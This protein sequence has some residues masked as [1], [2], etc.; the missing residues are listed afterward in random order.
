MRDYYKQEVAAKQA[1]IAEE[2]A[3][4]NARKEYLQQHVANSTAQADNNASIPIYN[5]HSSIAQQESDSQVA[6]AASANNSYYAPTLASY[7]LRHAH[8][9][10]TMLHGLKLA[11]Q[12][13]QTVEGCVLLLRHSLPTTLYRIQDHFRTWQPDIISL[14]LQC[15]R[16]LLDCNATRD[17]VL[18]PS[19]GLTAEESAKE[20]G[21]SAA[22][23][24]A[25]QSIVTG[26]V[27]PVNHP[28]D[29]N[30]GQN[31][32]ESN[33]AM[34]TSVI[35]CDLLFRYG[36]SR[37]RGV[38]DHSLRCLM[39]CSRVEAHRAF[40]FHCNLPHYVLQFFQEIGL[41][42]VG[43]ESV[44]A[45]LRLL[46][47][48][49]TT[50]HRLQRVL[51]EYKAIPFLC[52]AMK[53]FANSADVLIPAIALLHRLVGTLPQA[54][55]QALDHQVLSFVIPALSRLAH[56]AVIQRTALL[57]VQLLTKTSEGFQQLNSLKGAWQMV[58]QG[59][60]LGDE[61]V[62]QLPGP[63]QN[64]G[65]ALGDAPF[66]PHNEQLAAV[67]RNM[68]QNALQQAPKAAWTAH[69]LREFMGLSMAGQQLAIN[70]EQNLVFFE[71]LT[72][73]DILPQ[74]GEE[75]EAWFQRLRVFE[76]ES[77]VSLDEMVVTVQEMR[78]REGM[79]KK[80]LAQGLAVGV[81]G[82]EHIGE[83]S[84]NGGSLGHFTAKGLYVRGQQ[85]TT[86]S[87]Q[88]QDADLE[89]A[90]GEESA[91]YAPDRHTAPPS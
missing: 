5:I 69:S 63:L 54:M 67:A 19:L 6:M 42:S 86:Q 47:W 49:A 38:L 31:F 24:D 51:I 61:L 26:S 34:E 1:K 33:R 13:L 50:V 44:H 39:Q 65:W 84:G 78:R 82:M 45:F 9:E 40:L 81:A 29:F 18:C 46:N 14:V 71:L 72:T 27:Q 75:R 10:E 73:L 57:L 59:T 53:T 55:Q 41:A 32:S 74:P 90:F 20:S 66:R 80:M 22:H 89:D 2:K 43:V 37:P 79:R 83:D 28:N 87:L 23:N 64:K 56:D 68:A 60:L 62:H 88:A 3:K 4:R 52:R 70:T 8:E 12:N 30:D 7:L 76:K 48:M 77:E 15:L 17:Y 11:L 85:V 16:Q 35:V 25:E 91:A 58:T 36:R 21:N